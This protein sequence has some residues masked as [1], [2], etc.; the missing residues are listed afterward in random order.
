[1][2]C[3]KTATIDKIGRKLF[4]ESLVII[5]KTK[6]KNIIINSPKTASKFPAQFLT[7]SLIKKITITIQNKNIRTHKIII[8]LKIKIIIT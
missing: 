8:I 1:M 7:T 5:T 6:F 2:H 3:F 4:I